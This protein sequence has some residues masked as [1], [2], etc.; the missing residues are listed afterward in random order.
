MTLEAPSFD[1]P[2]NLVSLAIE[3]LKCLG[4]ATHYNNLPPSGTSHLNFS[5]TQGAFNLNRLRSA[6]WPRV[7]V[8]G[9]RRKMSFPPL[10]DGFCDPFSQAPKEEARLDLVA[11]DHYLR[12]WSM[13]VNLQITK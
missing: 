3:G 2:W 5:M 13:E 12:S 7:L 6:E 8:P 10:S 9:C 4:L 1:L 11:V